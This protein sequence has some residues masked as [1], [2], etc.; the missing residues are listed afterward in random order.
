MAY[1]F[2]LLPGINY[3]TSSYVH[4][5]WYKLARILLG[6][7]RGLEAGQCSSETGL[8]TSPSLR[9]L[10]SL[11]PRTDSHHIYCILYVKML[12]V[13]T[14]VCNLDPDLRLGTQLEPT[15]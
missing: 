14:L 6:L 8:G 9:M 2:L 11:K 4:P 5:Y 15:A 7:A 1:A 3:Q 13:M 10:S 12:I